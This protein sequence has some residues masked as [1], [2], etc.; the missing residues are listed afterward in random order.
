MNK[1]PNNLGAFFIFNRM[2]IFFE[3]VLDEVYNNIDLEKTY[4]VIPN[5]RSKIFLK[6]EILKKISVASISPQIFSIDAFIQKIADIKESP[7]TNQLFYLYECYMELSQKKD[8][9]SYSLFR[10]WSNTLLNDINDIE[11]GMA[12]YNEVFEKN[13]IE[14]VTEK[15]DSEEGPILVDF[16]FR[17]ENSIKKRQHTENHIIDMIDLYTTK[18]KKLLN[19]TN[20]TF[21]IYVFEKPGVNILDTENI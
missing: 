9:E 4:F 16:D 2:K 7:R 11:M 8:F 6:K 19:F 21:P 3:T 14:Y 10:K 5:Q 12:D 17:Y 20:E 18:L 15:Q 1:A 13:T